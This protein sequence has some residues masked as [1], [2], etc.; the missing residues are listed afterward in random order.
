MKTL[1]IVLILISTFAYG[2]DFKEK[3]LTTEIEEVRV[4]LKGAQISRSGKMWLPAGKHRVRIKQLSP[5]IDDKSIKV[6]GE[7]D[8]TILSVNHTLNYLDELKRSKQVD[9]LNAEIEKLVKQINREQVKIEVIKEQISLIRSNQKLGTKDGTNLEELQ[10]AIDLYNSRLLAI[11]N[12]QLETQ[13]LIE[14]LIEQQAKL[15]Y[16]LAELNATDDKP[17]G[18][19]EIR[20]QVENRTQGS[21]EISYL[22]GNA[23]WFPKYDIRVKDVENPME[24]IYKAD[25]YQNTGEDWE[26]VQLIFSNANPSASGSAPIIDPWYLNFTQF[27]SVYSTDGIYGLTS[28]PSNIREVQGKVFDSGTGNGLPGVNILVQGTTVGTITDRDGNY[29]L[30]VPEGGGNL[31]F[32]YIGFATVEQQIRNDRMDIALGEDLKQLSEV[33]VS[34]ASGRALNRTKAYAERSAAKSANYV[35]TTFVENQTTVE[36][37]IEDPYSLKSNGEKI[38]IDLREFEVPANYQYTVVPKLDPDA[39][40]QAQITDWNQYGLMDG[41]ANLYFEEGYVG[42]TIL[43]TKAF[44]DTLT[45]S[46]GRDRS[47]Q[48]RR[49]K[50]KEFLKVKTVAG[51]R[52]ET[53]EF[54]IQVRNNK[55]QKINLKISDQ[56]PVSVNNQIQVSHKELSGGKLDETTGIIEW[57]LELDPEE[58]RE[59]VLKY[60]VKYPKRET[61]ILE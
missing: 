52:V 33:V 29:R 27:T 53:R 43:N 56:V 17:T 45:V 55:K 1:T 24:L 14:E 54:T 39:F 20:V 35:N 58:N 11:K 8:F 44:K 26:N 40:L 3:E 46:L 15:E 41:E 30:T 57:I 6:K 36:F 42:R 4:F 61:V 50:S 13:E 9:S 34:S 23:G 31:V 12:R 48:V 16:Q 22:V 5:Y 59:L 49:D 7:G 32:N 51:N 37:R 28:R 19:I 38:T 10:K 60:E 25:L 47:V 18:E 21:F 2:Q